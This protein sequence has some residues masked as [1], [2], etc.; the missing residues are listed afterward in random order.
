L[1]ISKDTLRVL[2]NYQTINKSLIVNS[3]R[4][5]KT[6]TDTNTLYAEAQIEEEFPD[7]AIYDLTKFLSIIDLVDEPEFEF[8]EKFLTITNGRQT[9]KYSFADPSILNLKIPT[10]KIELPDIMAQFMLNQQDLIN[11]D[12]ASAKLSLPDLVI[13]K[14]EDDVLVGIVCDK[15]NSAA[16]SYTVVLEQSE[17]LTEV[18][19]SLNFKVEG[20]KI[21]SGDYWVEISKV[22]H[23]KFTNQHLD[24]VYFISLESDSVT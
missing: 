16:N 7:F 19:I 18:D 4:V 1:K 9:T 15:K 20:F 10:K 12:K 13:T 3:G 11:V 23:A 6:L 21:L 14:N 8:Y 5:I 22:K 2:K 17:L 24:L